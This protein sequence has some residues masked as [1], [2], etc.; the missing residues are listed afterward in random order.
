VS[1]K[2]YIKTKETLRA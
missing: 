2:F 1:Y